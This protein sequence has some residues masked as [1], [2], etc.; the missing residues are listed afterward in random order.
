MK[1]AGTSI[2]GLDAAFH[3]TTI[4]RMAM[5][6]FKL[7]DAATA[8]HLMHLGTAQ[9]KLVESWHLKNGQALTA[10]QAEHLQALARPHQGPS[11]DQRARAALAHLFTHG[12]NRQRPGVLAPVGAGS[13]VAAP[14]GGTSRVIVDF[15]NVPRGTRVET[16]AHG[17]G[18]MPEVNVGFVSPAFGY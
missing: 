18:R 2:N 11:F 13:A 4:G 1:A 14:P 8:K 5:I 3:G 16:K 9:K 12:G 7:Y 10:A 15:K 6:A 17:N